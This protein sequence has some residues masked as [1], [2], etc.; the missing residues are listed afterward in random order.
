MLRTLSLEE[1]SFETI[2]SSCGTVETH[3]YGIDRLTAAER[4]WLRTTAT[5]GLLHQ[6]EKTLSC[7][8]VVL[9]TENNTDIQPKKQHPETFDLQPKKHSLHE[10][11]SL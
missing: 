6:Y 3:F 2:M 1:A 8:G 11:V 10:W 4:A 7:M 5:Y 9:S